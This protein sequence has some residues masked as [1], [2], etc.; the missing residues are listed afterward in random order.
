MLRVMGSAFCYVFSYFEKPSVQQ[1]E[2]HTAQVRDVG[3]KEM[4]MDICM[5]LLS[6]GNHASQRPS[7]D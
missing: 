5:Y 2:E 7:Q 1:V 4:V 6:E 3:T